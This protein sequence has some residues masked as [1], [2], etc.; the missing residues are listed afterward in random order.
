MAARRR[1]AI[2][3]NQAFALV[4]F[5][6]ALIRD[7]LDNGHEV[8]AMAPDFDKQTLC[9]I[10]K[11]GAKPI[12]YSLSRAGINA[13]RDF[14]DAIK[15]VRLF[16]REKPDLVMCYT[17]K[18]VVYGIPAAALAGVPRRTA[19]IT[20]LGYGFGEAKSLRRRLVQL[21]AQRLYKFALR[22][23]FL[24]FVQNQDDA[25]EL[26]RKRLVTPD[27]LLVV[28]GSGVELDK[29]PLLEQPEIP[30]TFALAAR[31]LEEKGVREYVE[32][33]RRIKLRYPSTRFLLLGDT[34]TNPTS[35]SRKEIL[36]WVG[37][38]VVEWPGHVDMREWMAKFH[39]F[40]LP[41]YREGVPRSSQEAAASGRAIITTD[42]PGCRETVVHGQNGLLVPVR[43]VAA[44]AGAMQEL[45]EDPELVAR[46]GNAS[47]ALA[48]ERF[49]V[50][51]INQ[52]MLNAAGLLA[53]D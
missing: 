4:N 45:V 6:S 8:L 52:T 15:L 21:V 9:A 40:V 47:R 43:D 23:A 16:R 7:L 36:G 11:L 29:W 31:L 53:P 26:T 19:L 17:I 32:A 28:N 34:D 2:V 35:V 39:V 41:S 33:A 25:R 18:P 27:K 20:G 14:A 51:A 37:E 12:T 48:E 30:I 3:G 13:V 44:L 42:A 10:E 24:V 22:R 5:R 1:V 46:M 38:G 49:D 50:R